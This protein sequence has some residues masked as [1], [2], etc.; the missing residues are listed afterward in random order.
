MWGH[1]LCVEALETDGTNTSQMIKPPICRHWKRTGN[2]AY[3]DKCFFSHDL[4]AKGSSSVGMHV[5][6]HAAPKSSSS[7]VSSSSSSSVVVA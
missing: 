4:D 5:N 2:C 3:G 1:M 6:K 7:S